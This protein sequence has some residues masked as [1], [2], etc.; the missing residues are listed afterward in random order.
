MQVSPGRCSA[1][2]AEGDFF[3]ATDATASRA[4]NGNRGA[5]LT[6][7]ASLDCYRDVL[8][9]ACDTFESSANRAFNWRCFPFDGMKFGALTVL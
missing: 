5:V 7:P 4:T 3:V 9:T 8:R 6:C 1:W 2:K